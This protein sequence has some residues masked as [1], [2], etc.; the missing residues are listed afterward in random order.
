MTL[1]PLIYIITFVVL[2]YVDHLHF[3][4]YITILAVWL[5]NDVFQQRDHD[6]ELA[7]SIGQ[8]L[9]LKNQQLTSRET[10]LDGQLF[11]ANEQVREATPW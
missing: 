5:P 1:L 6:L 4:I 10:S 7:A 9:L 11:L 3:L 2:G 8:S